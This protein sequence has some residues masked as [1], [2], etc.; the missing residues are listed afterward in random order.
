MHSLSELAS[1]IHT[2]YGKKP[3]TFDGLTLTYPKVAISLGSH[4][5]EGALTEDWVV[6][7][8]KSTS[9]H[10][11]KELKKNLQSILK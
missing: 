2:K 3:K 9:I 11:A 1:L 4:F 7:K 8:G 5:E 10:T 6:T